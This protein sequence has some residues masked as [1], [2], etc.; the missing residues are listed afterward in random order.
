MT[1]HDAQ[2]DDEQRLRMSESEQHASIVRSLLDF[3]PEGITVA[4]GRDAVISTR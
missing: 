3:V 4:F 1:R 2:A